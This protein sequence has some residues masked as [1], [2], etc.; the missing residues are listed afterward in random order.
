MHHVLGTWIVQ[1]EVHCMQF[2]PMYLHTILVRNAVMNEIIVIFY[3]YVCLWKDGVLA[4][5]LLT[6]KPRYNK[7]QS[8]LTVK[9]IKV[10]ERTCNKI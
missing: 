3:W 1:Q 8:D 5:F 10:R 9:H 2:A 6:T 4:F 7:S